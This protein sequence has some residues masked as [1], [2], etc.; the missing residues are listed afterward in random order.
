MQ[1]PRAML[2][3]L[4]TPAGALAIVAASADAQAGPCSALPNPLIIESGDTQE[5]LL[6]DLGRKLRVSTAGAMTVIYR[7]AGTCAVTKDLYQKNKI[8]QAAVLNYLPSLAEKPMWTPADAPLQCEVDTVGGLNIDLGIGATFISSCDKNAPPAGTALIT[9][10]IQGYG[11]IVPK[12]GSTQ[13]AMT[14]EEG[15]FVFGFGA[16]GQVD[17]WTNDDNI[18]TRPGTKST[19]L[20]LA[21]LMGID[22]ITKLKGKPL[23][24]SKDV[25]AAVIGSA[26]PDKAIGL[27]GTEIF[28]ANRDKVNLLAFQGFK[29]RYAYY[30]DSTST[31]FDKR[32]LRDGHYLPW[33]PT[34][35]IAAVDG[36]GHP[37]VGNARTFVE[38]VLG[39]KT[40]ADVDGLSSVVAKG[41]V[42]HCAMKVS[43]EFDGGNLSLYDPPKPCGCYYE[44]KVPNGSTVCKTCANDDSVCGGGKCRYGYCEA[45]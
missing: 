26:V 33:S 39:E 19:A 20:T 17:P 13:N 21:A 32:N 36:E 29:Q 11:L 31:S 42:P 3:R 12:V 40:L 44:S 22:P 10:P 37:S 23:D 14:A 15:Y 28:D 35:Y 6:K 24:G 9:G 1:E 30:P 8:A 34:V 38:L 5:P 41:L 43:R 27:M 7:T 2:K 25:L 18:F 16:A 45:K 4:L